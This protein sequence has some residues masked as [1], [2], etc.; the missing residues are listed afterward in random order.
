MN[1]DADGAWLTVGRSRVFRDLRDF[2]GDQ[3]PVG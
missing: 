2:V 1:D 3:V